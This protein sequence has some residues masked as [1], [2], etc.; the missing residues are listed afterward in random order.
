MQRTRAKYEQHKGPRIKERP[1]YAI[2]RHVCDDVAA[3]AND[4]I[5]NDRNNTK[6]CSAY[7]F[8]NCHVKAN[9]KIYVHFLFDN[10]IDH[11]NNE[12][13]SG[14]FFVI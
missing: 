2:I 1:S 12:L 5:I 6:N 4:I 13:E 14:L 3:T 9:A 10:F 8:N 11:P 7:G